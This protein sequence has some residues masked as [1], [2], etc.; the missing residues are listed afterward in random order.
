MGKVDYGID[1]PGV[2]R[3]LLLIGS[4]LVLIAL[5]LPPDWFPP[6]SEIISGGVLMPGLCMI[7]VGSLMVLY[8]K[9]GKF[10][11]RDRMLG[12]YPWKGDEMVLDVG[13]GLGL[14]MIGVA[15]RLTKGKA[16]GIDVFNKQDLSGN[17]VARLKSNIAL[18]GVQ[19]NTIIREEN[20][21]HTEFADE[22][23]DVVISNLCLHNIYNKKAR[24]QACQEIFRLLKPGG[25][26]IISDFKHTREYVSAF[27]NAGM[28]VHRTGTYLLDTFPPLTIIVAEKSR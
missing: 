2:I 13:T 14:L 18:E 20:I 1:A 28:K 8:A 11:Q 5:F 9:Y 7:L 27:K 22:F 12:L 17:N 15:K 24:G 4:L 21:I 10:R 19:A 16:Y 3:N 26:A 6:L 25:K 23:F